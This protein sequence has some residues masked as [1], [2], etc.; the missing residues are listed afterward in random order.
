ML[1]QISLLCRLQ[2]SNLFG[3]NEFRY[4]KDNAKK[5]RYIGHSFAWLL[6]III[7][8]S[9][10]TAFSYGMGMLGMA[11]IIPVYLYAIV[12]MITLFF[13]FFKA[14]SVLFSMK[15]YEMLVSLPFTKT[16]IIVS[17]FIEMYVTALAT[18]I[19]VMVPGLVVYGI[20]EKPTVSF[21]LVS[22]LAV[23]FL[24]M[25][26]LTT[27]CIIGA[28]IKAISARSRHKSIGETILMVAVI[29]VVMFGSFSSSA[30]L[31][32]MDEEAIRNLAALAAEQIGKAY[33]PAI[34]YQNAIQGELISLFLLIAVPTAVF[35]LFAVILQKFY[36]GICMAIN[37]S[38]AKNNYKLGELGTSSLLKALW[39]KEWKRYF[40]SSGYVT[41][42]IVG[43]IL[44][45]V[46]AVVFLAAGTEEVDKMFAMTGL[47]QKASPFLLSAVLSMMSI[48]SCTISMEGKNYWMLQTLPIRPKDVYK[49]KMLLNFSIGA[50]FVIVS[51]VITCIAVKASL[52]EA[53]WIFVIPF[54]YLCFSIVSGLAANLKFPVLNWENEVRVVK[55]S[56]SVFVTMLVGILCSIVPGAVVLF[57]QGINTN[58]MLAGI[59]AALLLV[60]GM[61]YCYVIRQDLP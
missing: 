1:K 19:L 22:F 51:S 28:V 12:S 6:V 8:L 38:A 29:L 46:V 50:P 56:A 47:M 7:L 10:V 44:T 49:A 61:L 26:P 15:S 2:C 25:L 33:P 59:T 18:G 43:Y 20:Y 16:A 60:T 30:Q 34:L 23:V 41:N 27:A 39:K 37:A 24:P 14:G 48:T 54:G 58:L 3:I 53:V 42:T 5:R 32:Q 13:S 35:V 4:T 9:Y 11:D 21:Y 40:A 31:E 55:Q 36:Q 45:L 17:R 52:A 57:V